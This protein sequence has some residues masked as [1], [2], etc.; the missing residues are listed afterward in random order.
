MKY[1][2]KL[3]VGSMLIG[4]CMGLVIVFIVFYTITVHQ[5]VPEPN[6]ISITPKG[7]EQSLE[8][9]SLPSPHSQSPTPLTDATVSPRP[10]SSPSRIS[11]QPFRWG[12]YTGHSVTEKKDFESR[13][14]H[15]M[16][17]VA[18]FVHWGNE[19]EFP[20]EM[21]QEA[22]AN[23]QKL[24][25]FWEAKDYSVERFDDERFSYQAILRGDWDSYL[26]SF[27][28]SAKA[29]QLPV[30]L[31]PFEEMNGNWSPWAITL[32]GNSPDLHKQAYKKIAQIFQDAPNVQMGWT[33]NNDSV[34]NVPENTIAGLYP[35]NEWV[36]VIGIDGFNF[37]D[38]WQTP[39]V[40]FDRVL[41]QVKGF[42]KPIIL[43]SIGTAEGDKKA[44]WISELGVLLSQHP[45]VRGFI[46]F[47][48]DKEKDWRVWSDPQSL[49]SFRAL[50]R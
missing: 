34:P 12:A 37:D 23:G 19:R 27:K 45:E 8:S 17:Y 20:S 38:P 26:T 11:T 41:N 29:A 42:G 18:V 4:A 21:A 47:N 24:V 25:I 1:W 43:T 31:I 35:G 14:G 32:N 28:D 15:K 50:V 49:E 48:E 40:V 22:K 3:D 13:V 10:T 7:V 9:S 6:S 39:P 44:P 36:D 5:Q 46:W 30:I 16:D 33:V 2:Q